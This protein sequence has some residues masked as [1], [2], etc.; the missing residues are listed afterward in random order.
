MK[1]LKTIIWKIAIVCIVIFVLLVSLVRY[2][3]GGY[4]FKEERKYEKQMAITTE[5]FKQIVD[6]DGLDYVDYWKGANER[7]YDIDVDVQFIA[8]CTIDDV[9]RKMTFAYRNNLSEMKGNCE[10]QAMLCS[11]VLN[12]AFEE[13]DFKD[14]YAEPVIGQVY[15]Y[16][17]NVHKIL[18]KIVP[19]KYKNFV[20]NHCVVKVHY[21]N[22][23]E[24]YYDPSI[25]DG[26]W[27]INKKL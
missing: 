18:V 22:G 3:S 8:E 21:S 5:Q 19:K 27:D 9:S 7:L 13:L 2:V 16:N 11:A 1:M 26:C 20:V 6:Y 24:K 10:G 4:Y 14:C 23:E 25:C 15:F 12:K 17:T